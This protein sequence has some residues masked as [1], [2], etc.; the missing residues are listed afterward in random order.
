M[1]A[2]PRIL[3]QLKLLDPWA[4]TL[5]DFVE[6]LLA[7]HEPRTRRESEIA[8]VSSVIDG[9]FAN[10]PPAG[11]LSL[12]DRQLRAARLAQLQAVFRAYA[13]NPS[14]ALQQIGPGQADLAG[15]ATAQRLA[16]TVTAVYAAAWEEQRYREQ[17][18]D[19]L[20]VGVFFGPVGVLVYLASKRPEL[21]EA[22]KRVGKSVQ[23]T[24][25][26][27]LPRPPYLVIGMVV[28]GVAVGLAALF[29]RRV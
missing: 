7:V 15:F 12:V 20:M 21:V 29:A 17:L 8:K 19:L 6:A 1:A 5:T 11:D 4:A 23:T 14:L 16:D 3:A 28:G 25:D 26:D 22:A 2:L 13:R 24:V 18:D 9:Q 27:V 10:F